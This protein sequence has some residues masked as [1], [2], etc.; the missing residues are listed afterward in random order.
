MWWVVTGESLGSDCDAPLREELKQTY[1]V[2]AGTEVRRESD[3]RTH[4]QNLKLCPGK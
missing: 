4:N 1:L 3:T 2:A